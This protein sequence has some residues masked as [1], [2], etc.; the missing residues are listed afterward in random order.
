LNCVEAQV[1]IKTEENSFLE[2]EPFNDHQSDVKSELNVN[3]STSQDYEDMEDCPLVIRKKG[4]KRTLQ[5]DQRE[6]CPLGSSC[7]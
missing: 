2:E 3:D 6:I 5:K 4:P 7:P 1:E